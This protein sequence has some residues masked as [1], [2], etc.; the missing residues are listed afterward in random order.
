MTNPQNPIPLE[1]LVLAARMPMQPISAE[2]LMQNG[3]IRAAIGPG[4]YVE[5]QR[6]DGDTDEEAYFSVGRIAAFLEAVAG[7]PSRISDG[8]AVM[9]ALFHGSLAQVPPTYPD[10]SYAANQLATAPDGIVELEARRAEETIVAFAALVWLL[11]Q[12]RVASPQT[13]DGLKVDAA[14]VNDTLWDGAAVKV[15][16][17]DLGAYLLQLAS[18]PTQYTVDNV[19]PLA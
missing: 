2:Q 17:S 14:V 5:T 6:V 16:E 19:R 3:A 11:E 12:R 9:D 18:P 15:K 4:A 8:A 13:S 10:S 7:D 1:N